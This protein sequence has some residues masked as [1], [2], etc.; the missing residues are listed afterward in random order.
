[1]PDSPPLAED[2]VIGAGTP[3]SAPPEGAKGCLVD[4]AISNHSGDET[5]L[6]AP[7]EA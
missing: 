5:R 6:A 2:R 3:G 7:K 4:P 1:L